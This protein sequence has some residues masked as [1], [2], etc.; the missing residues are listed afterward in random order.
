V[1]Y[2]WFIGDLEVILDDYDVVFIWFRW[3]Y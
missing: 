3:V 1:V 2:R